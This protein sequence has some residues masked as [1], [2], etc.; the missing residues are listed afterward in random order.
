MKL[1]LDTHIF[2][3]LIERRTGGFPPGVQRLLA[4]PAGEFHVSVA[5]L[6]EIAIKWRL[7]KLR[8]TPD[9]RTL[10]ELI[11]GLGI[12]L[13]PINGHRALAS[14]EPEPATRDPFDKML[15]AQCQVENLRLVT[16]DR[17]LVAHPFAAKAD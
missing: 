2:L 4:E 6:W 13:V 9:L 10:P 8:L 17:A 16:I 15:L 3:A 14:V 12:D 1:L 5:S 7:G 11:A